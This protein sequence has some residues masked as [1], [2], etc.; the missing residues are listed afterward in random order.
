MNFYSVFAFF[1]DS[2]AQQRGSITCNCSPSSSFLLLFPSHQF[3]R[4]IG[5][6][7]H[8]H[9]STPPLR[10]SSEQEKSLKCNNILVT[11]SERAN[12]HKMLPPSPNFNIGK[13][14]RGKA[15]DW[16]AKRK[17]QISLPSLLW[18]KYLSKRQLEGFSLLEAFFFFA[19]ACACVW[20]MCVCMCPR[21]SSLPLFFSSPAFSPPPLFIFWKSSPQHFPNGSEICFAVLLV[22][23]QKSAILQ[24]TPGEKEKI[25]KCSRGGNN[26]SESRETRIRNR[27][28]LSG[29]LSP[30]VGGCGGNYEMMKSENIS[31]SQIGPIHIRPK[32]KKSSDLF[33]KVTPHNERS[34]NIVTTCFSHKR[35]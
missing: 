6:K 19:V 14:R 3:P 24:P 27:P 30:S 11:K 23:G 17:Q 13:G 22:F 1:G 12:A 21:D 31:C 2:L 29:K 28:P 9:Q 4:I 33:K 7:D 25:S 10:A 8:H 5:G 26:I 34:V 32:K 15:A 35:N 18:K 20:H 16:T